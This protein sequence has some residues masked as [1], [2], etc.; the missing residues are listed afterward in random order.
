MLVN[1]KKIIAKILNTPLVIERGTCETFNFN[2]LYDTTIYTEPDGSKWLRI[3]HHNNPSVNLFA[4]SDNFA[5]GVYKNENMWYYIENVC[6]SMNHYEFMVKQKNT[7]TSDEQKFRW[8]QN[9]HPVGATHDQVQPNNVTR[10][11]TEGYTDSGMGGLYVWSNTNTGTNNARMSISNG[12]A[13]NWYG[14]LGCWTAYQGGLPGYPNQNCT[15]GYI[16]LYIRFEPQYIT[17]WTY[18]KW[19][20]GTAECW[21]NNVFSIPK[22]NQEGSVFW[23]ESTFYTYPNNLFIDI[24][25]V[26]IT[27]GCG[28]STLLWS[29][30]RTNSNTTLRWYFTGDTSGARATVLY[31]IHAV[32]HWGEYDEETN[33]MFA[34]SFSQEQMSKA[35][36]RALIEGSGH[37]YRENSNWTPSDL[38]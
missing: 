11:T 18:R 34:P 13:G 38:L 15:T 23:W 32:G 28:N 21:Y 7:D 19:T 29:S 31:N 27:C 26:N 37:I 16:D 3:F 12:T 8:V 25:V 1:I 36:I 22:M 4:S 2:E 30:L 35:S 20:D 14:A 33:V 10:I 9:V 24:P 5:A 6:S 17:K